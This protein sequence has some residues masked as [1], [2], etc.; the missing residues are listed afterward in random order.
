MDDMVNKFLL[1]EDKF[2]H[3][4]HLRQFCVPN[5]TEELNLKVFNL[6]TWVKISTKHIWCECKCNIHGGKCHSKWNYNKCWYE[7]R[8]H[9]SIWNPATCSYENGKYLVNIIN[10]SV[11]TCDELIEETKTSYNKF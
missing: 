4:I 7:C 11:I 9:H 6:I 5:K 3:E 8:K 1:A 10:D 2:M